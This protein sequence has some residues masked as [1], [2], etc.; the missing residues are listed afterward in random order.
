VYWHD[1]VLWLDLED[2]RD[3][4][5]PVEAVKVLGFINHFAEKSWATPAWLRRAIQR[6]AEARGWHIHGG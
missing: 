3:Y 5:V 2:G 4:E 1:G 6:I